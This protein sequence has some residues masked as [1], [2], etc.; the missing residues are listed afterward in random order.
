M[1]KE[2]IGGVVGGVGLLLGASSANKGA[3]KAAD[4]TRYAADQASAVQREA[5]AQNTATLSPFVNTGLGAMGN[6]NALLG[7]NGG[8]GG[9]FD[10]AQYFAANPDVA[11]GFGQQNIYS[12][13][14]E[15]AKAHWEGY[16]SKEGRASPF[17]TPASAQQNAEN[18][19][20]TFR[21]STGYKFRLDQGL[22]AVNGGYAGAGTIKSGAAMKAINDYGQGMASQEF[23]N[24]LNALGNQQQLGLSAGS[25]LAGVSQNSANNLGQIAM[26]TGDNLANAALLK[27]QNNGQAINSL[28]MIG[29]GILGRQGGGGFNPNT[30][31]WAQGTGTAM[32][33][34]G[35]A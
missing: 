10:T 1:P 5:R 3:A 4:A 28:A 31:Q 26:N 6:V 8:G 30:S 13:P 12:T 21:N 15:F 14:D 34:N 22:D 24:Y 19:F 32:N 33:L 35:F 17:A 18:A 9:G 11:A 16:G 23:G 2:I 25:A 7:I 27:S 29:S 20:N